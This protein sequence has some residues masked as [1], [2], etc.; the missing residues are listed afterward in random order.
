MT[1]YNESPELEAVYA[2]T[3]KK[4]DGDA[5]LVVRLILQG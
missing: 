1:Q 3:H 5:E 4:S 2:K